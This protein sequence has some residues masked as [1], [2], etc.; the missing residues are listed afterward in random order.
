MLESIPRKADSPALVGR[1]RWGHELPNRLENNLEF[2]GGIGGRNLRPPI[3]QFVLGKLKHEVLGKAPDVPPNLLIQS[4]GRNLV[5][6]CQITV[7]HH[8]LPTDQQ[9]RLFDPFRV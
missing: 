7:Q 2:V 1:C 8:L 3:R 4:L 5:K 6:V 9:N